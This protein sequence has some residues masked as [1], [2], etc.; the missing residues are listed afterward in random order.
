[1]FSSNI[2]IRNRAPHLLGWMASNII[3][4]IVELY[5]IKTKKSIILDL[6][7]IMP[8]FSEISQA[9]IDQNLISNLEASDYLSHNITVFISNLLIC[10]SDFFPSVAGKQ[11]TQLWQ[12]SALQNYN[13][14]YCLCNAEQYA[15]WGLL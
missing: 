13:D 7:K 8:A 2:G 12:Y 9:N 14:N 11:D 6:H 15:V 4:F 5:F 3:F 1:M 10:C